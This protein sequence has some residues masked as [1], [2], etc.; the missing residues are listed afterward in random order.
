MDTQPGIILF[1]MIAPIRQQCSN[2]IT[3]DTLQISDS[4]IA[5]HV[6]ERQSNQDLLLKDY[7]DFF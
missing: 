5:I 1:K 6:K 3:G 7:I 4:V 2:V